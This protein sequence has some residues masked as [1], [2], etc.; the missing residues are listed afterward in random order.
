MSLE[1]YQQ[2]TTDVTT[3]LKT[4]FNRVTTPREA[5]GKLDFG[6]I[7]ILVEGMRDPN[8][9][10][11]YK[12][13]KELID[14]DYYVP[15]HHFALKHPSIP[16]AYVQIDVE[17]SPGSGTEDGAELFKWTKFMKGDSDLVQIIGVIHRSLGLTMNDRGLHVRVEEVQAYNKKKSM[18]FLTRDPDEAMDFYGYDKAKYHQGFMDETDLFDWATNGRWF[19]WKVYEDRDE[20]SKDRTRMIQR[21]MF[22][23]FVKEYMPACGKGTV[24][25]RTSEDEA[26]ARDDNPLRKMVLEEALQTFNKRKEYEAVMMEHWT[27]GV[28]EA[29]WLQINDSIPLQDASRGITLKGLKRWVAFEDGQP[30]ITKEPISG[31]QKLKWSDYVSNDSVVDVLAWIAENREQIYKLEKDRTEEAKKAAMKN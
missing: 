13:I 1:T 29:L 18:I 27:K 24:G 6:D 8:D 12:T 17:I 15:S 28:E 20:V 22:R 10:N 21:H 11:I 3:K 9:K 7:D 5:P 16:D 30:Y 25:P 14:A 23:R 31:S 4:L 19:F 2:V 26:G